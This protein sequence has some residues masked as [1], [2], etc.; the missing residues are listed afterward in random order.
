[1]QLGNNNWAFSMVE[2]RIRFI[3]KDIEH[4]FLHS[5]GMMNIGME[6]AASVPPNAVFSHLND[7]KFYS[8]CFIRCNEFD[9]FLFFSVQTKARQ[10]RR[11]SVQMGTVPLFHIC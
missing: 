6:I 1:M 11:E 8:T 4:L 9:T 2:N 7:R 5:T 3:R 10:H